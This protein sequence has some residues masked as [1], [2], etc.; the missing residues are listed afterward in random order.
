MRLPWISRAEHRREVTCLLRGY[1]E[2][3]ETTSR[4]LTSERTLR[5]ALLVSLASADRR[6][7]F[8]SGDLMILVRI[9]QKLMESGQLYGIEREFAEQLTLELAGFNRDYRGDM[10]QPE[11]ERRLAVGR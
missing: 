6:T 3:L 1:R 10:R 2:E 11:T 8:E 4:A 9:K 7:D 5:R